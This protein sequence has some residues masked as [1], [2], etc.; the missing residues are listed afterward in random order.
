MIGL[1]LLSVE[2]QTSLAL[3]VAVVFD[4]LARLNNAKQFYSNSSKLFT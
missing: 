3:N 2:K 1:D 4:T